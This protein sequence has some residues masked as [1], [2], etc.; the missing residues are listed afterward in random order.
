M[1]AFHS[2]IT[3]CQINEKLWQ[4]YVWRL[5]T[6]K[7]KKKKKKRGG[8]NNQLI[9]KHIYTEWKTKMSR[10]IQ[11]F[12]ESLSFFLIA[13][14]GSCIRH[15]WDQKD[16][17]RLKLLTSYISQAGGSEW[18][19][20]LFQDDFIMP[21]GINTTRFHDWFCAV[22]TTTSIEQQQ[23]FSPFTRCRVIENWDFIL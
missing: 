5:C 17:S 22:N 6:Q 23:P 19:R 16:Q 13:W 2:Q 7:Y 18:I 12:E 9:Y 11:L 3:D 14:A 1:S 8:K 20:T 10:P 15:A 4:K 21:V